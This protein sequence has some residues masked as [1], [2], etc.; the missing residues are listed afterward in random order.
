MHKNEEKQVF[1]AV[2]SSQFPD[3]ES[4][5][6]IILWIYNDCSLPWES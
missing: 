6:Y 4:L 2:T 3:L 1:K 5:A